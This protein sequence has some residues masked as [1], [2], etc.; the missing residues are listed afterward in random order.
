ML[1]PEQS[2]VIIAPEGQ[3][4]EVATRF[5]RIGFDKVLGYV[6]ERKHSSSLIKTM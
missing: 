2:V 5:A 6:A 4:Q 3:E 1:T